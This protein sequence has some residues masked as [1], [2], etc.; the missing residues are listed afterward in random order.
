MDL[1][2]WQRLERFHHDVVSFSV[3]R[4]FVF[5]DLKAR[6]E[7]S[8]EEA[9]DTKQNKQEMVEMIEKIPIR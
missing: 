4:Q 9:K 5:D 1:V 6:W 8:L 2:L 7:V 3:S